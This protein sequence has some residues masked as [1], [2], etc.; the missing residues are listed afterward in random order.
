MELMNN[1]SIFE[2]TY[3][4]HPASGCYV[5][6]LCLGLDATAGCS[7]HLTRPTCSFQTW[8]FFLRS[9]D[10]SARSADSP[11]SMCDPLLESKTAR[12]VSGR[13]SG[14]V[15]V[16]ELFHQQSAE[17]RP[18]LELESWESFRAEPAT[19]QLI[20][21]PP[22]FLPTS[23]SSPHPNHSSTSLLHLIGISG[24]WLINIW[25]NKWSLGMI[26]LFEKKVV[27]A[28]ANA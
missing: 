5:R 20:V 26:A 27:I 21:A 18:F 3:L 24:A 7:C 6:H 19:L 25:W 13:T 17:Q 15:K 2:L 22:A 9:R 1:G 4:G 16:S 23:L 12:L 8:V 28:L 14:R 10:S 11:F